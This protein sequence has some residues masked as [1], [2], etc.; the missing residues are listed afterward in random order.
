MR[1]V[2]RDLERTR[3]DLSSAIQSSMGSAREADR[4]RELAK[5]PYG[6]ASLTHDD[7]VTAAVVDRRA[8]QLQQ[9]TRALEDIDAGRYGVCR[10]C[11]E[12]I[13]PAR[14][15]VVPFA[16]HCVACQTRLESLPRAA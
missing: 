12:P 11:E 4:L 8:R 16:T 3:R 10:E 5:D 13:P 7:E 14:L 6:T 15:E 1:N 2:K 9:V